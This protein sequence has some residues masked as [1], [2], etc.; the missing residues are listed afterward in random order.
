MFKNLDASNSAD[1]FADEEVE[2]NRGYLSGYKPRS[3]TDQMLAL[4]ASF[5]RLESFDK[6]A[7]TRNLPPGAEE[8]FLVP[9]WQVIASTYH[10]A[11]EIVFAKLKQSREGRIR[12]YREGEFGQNHLRETAKKSR[13]FQVR[14]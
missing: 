13:L 9:R 3:V 4:R 5:P 6:G 8:L 10:R 1:E 12:D 7:I 2:S 11:T 14:V